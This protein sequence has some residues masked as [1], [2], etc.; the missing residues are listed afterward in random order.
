[1]S[2]TKNVQVQRT[3]GGGWE[4]D[5]VDQDKLESEDA[6]NFGDEVDVE[7]V[8]APKGDSL[9]HLVPKLCLLV[10]KIF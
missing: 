6:T 5:A 4:G 3:L 2:G 7:E 9:R 10:P 1:M 8:R